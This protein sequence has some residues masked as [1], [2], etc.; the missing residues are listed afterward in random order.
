[1]LTSEFINDIKLSP[2]ASILA[3]T[4][5]ALGMLSAFLVLLIYLTDK[6]IERHNNDYSDIYRIETQFNLPNGDYVKSAQVPL[7][8]LIALQNEKN[9][10]NTAYAL[11]LSSNLQV[12]DLT[13]A[14][15]DIYAV[16]PNFFNIINPYQLNNDNNN[17]YK[18]NLSQ[19]R[20]NLTRN[21]IIITPEFNQQY[22]H[23]DNPIGHVITLGSKGQFVI[24]MINLHTGSRFNTKAV[25]AFS[26]E[27][28]DGY[29]DK[30]HDWYDMH[31]YVFITMAAGEKPSHEQLDALV[32]HY[33]PQ[34]PGA[35]FSPEEFIQLSARNITDIHYDNGLPD[36]ISTVI[37][38]P[39]LYTLYAAG[40]FIFITTIINF[41]NI[42]N[43]INN[44]KKN[45]F[46][47]KKSIGA[48]RYQ[49]LTESFSIAMLQTFF[50]LLLTILFLIILIPLSLDIRDLILTQ[51]TGI[52]LISFLL[53]L[54]AVYTA[55]LFA[56]FIYLYV[57]VFPEQSGHHNIYNEQPI[58]RYIHRVTLCIQT[59]I[60]GIIIYLW[61]GMLTQNSF[62]QHHNFGY[63]KEN[64]L[65]FPLSD[66]L[67]NLSSLIN[68][69]D[70]LKNTSN[71]EFVSLSSW[72]PFDMSRSNTSIY[73]LNQQEKDKLV[74]VSTLNVNKHFPDTWGMK[75]LAGQ[76]NVLISSEDN[77][78]IHAIVTQSFMTLM[79]L[80]SYD[81]TLNSIF[82]IKSNNAER[83]VRILR[84]VNDFYLA[85][86]DKN[87]TP[88][89]I[90]IEDKTQ[91]YGALKLQDMQ[92]IGAIKKTLERYRVTPTQIQTV[93]NLH[94]EYFNNSRLIQQTANSVTLVSILLILISTIIIS[95][96]ETKRIGKTLKIMESIGGSIYTHIIFFIQQNIAPI[97]IAVIISF[98]VGFFLL[99][100]WLVQYNAVNSLSYVNAA[101]TLLTFMISIIVI[102]TI[103][104]ILNNNIHNKKK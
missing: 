2:L 68:L 45:S 98:S 14:K 38:K 17:P 93:S 18:S 74:T 24:N 62:M 57:A 75:V 91:R 49:L 11:R 60:S 88:L 83:K 77:N 23:L 7:P 32:T 53:T 31:A 41:F 87:A 37:A 66:E 34:L 40:V 30:R 27:L 69:Q 51:D 44:N 73:H 64:I 55:I 84:V 1:M 35:P 99:H 81:E 50:V 15:V 56:H 63:E 10:K 101:G 89:L 96:S 85:D 48:S 9:I 8:L 29:H 59:A 72:Q 97:V 21:E 95:I 65:T 71:I 92:D 54:I 6:S 90:Y 36:E 78:V 16:S 4:I 26:P 42:N 12:N 52:L 39:Y 46:Q 25:I 82:Y 5:T 103:T 58:S 3:I 80:S 47:I 104:L 19:H 28:I 94:K 67:I 70:E 33:A 79:G 22:L 76:E 43:V 100:R 86:R 20:L 61:A 102:M 13:H